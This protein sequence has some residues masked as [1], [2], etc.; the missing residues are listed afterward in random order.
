MHAPVVVR[1][2]DMLMRDAETRDGSY[3]RNREQH[4][5]RYR[6]ATER[7]SHSG[8]FEQIEG[9]API[10]RCAPPADL[11]QNGS[12]RFSVFMTGRVLMMSSV[13]MF[14]LPWFRFFSN[15]HYHTLSLRSSIP[16]HRE[17]DKKRGDGERKQYGVLFQVITSQS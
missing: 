17:T 16:P 2:K 8:L 10:P 7:D 1:N 12:K 5:P 11:Q 9:A 15:N 13:L 6:I 3:L 14:H 4:I